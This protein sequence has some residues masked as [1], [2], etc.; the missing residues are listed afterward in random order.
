MK[1]S[2][3][4]WPNKN[5]LMHLS[6]ASC[7]WRSNIGRLPSTERDFFFCTGC[8][9][10]LEQTLDLLVHVLLPVHFLNS[11]WIILGVLMPIVCQCPGTHGRQYDKITKDLSCCMFL[12][13]LS[14]IVIVSLVIASHFTLANTRWWWISPQMRLVRE[15]VSLQQCNPYS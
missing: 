10:L 4:H 2:M 11:F 7:I 9:K 6:E 1:V 15:C 12:M 5:W 13:L 8:Y 14:H 3:L